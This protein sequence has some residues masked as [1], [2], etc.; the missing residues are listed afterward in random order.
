MD[1]AELEK[2]DITERIEKKGQFSYLS[3][4]F[5]VSEFRKK[6]PEGYWVWDANENGWPYTKTDSGCFVGVTVFPDSTLQGFRQIHPILDHR[7]KTIKEPDAFQVNT[8]MQRCLVKAIAIATGIGLH[9]YTGEDLPPDENGERKT[10]Q[11]PRQ[12]AQKQNE[13]S[14]FLDAMKALAMQNREDYLKALGYAGYESAK[15][16]PEDQQTK[17]YESVEKAMAA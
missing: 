10:K 17:I 13:Q 16:V 15:D 14:A 9:I 4:P 2:T 5:A 1:F 11:K 8:S 6:C 3:W 7:N 12:S